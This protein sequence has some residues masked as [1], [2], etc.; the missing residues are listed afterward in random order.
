LPAEN[1][2]KTVILWA[3]AVGS[4]QS[5][6]EQE[7]GNG[8]SERLNAGCFYWYGGFGTVESEEML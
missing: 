7:I 3:R 6:Q 4:G 8:F 2:A 1:G 5:V